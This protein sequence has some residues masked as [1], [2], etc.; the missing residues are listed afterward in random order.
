MTGSTNATLMPIDDCEN[1][2]ER[3]E[4]TLEQGDVCKYQFYMGSG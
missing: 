2:C 1:D 4:F 3:F